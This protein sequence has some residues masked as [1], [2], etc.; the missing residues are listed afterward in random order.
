MARDANAHFHIDGAFGALGVLAPEIAPALGGLALAD[1][2]AFD[3][4][5][6]RAHVPYDAGCILVRDGDLATARPSPAM[7]PT[8]SARGPRF[9]PA[10]IG[11]PATMGLEAISGA[12]SAR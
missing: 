2:L 9:K 1:S 12:G 7:R 11:G 10:A 3:F 4:Q 5:R 6:E 8:C